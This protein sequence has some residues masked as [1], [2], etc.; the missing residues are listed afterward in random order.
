MNPT[1]SARELGSSV[2][3]RI[4]AHPFAFLAVALG[5]GYVA[6]GGLSSVITN[7]LMR[8]GGGLA[9]RYFILP[10]LSQTVSRVLGISEQD[11]GDD[12]DQREGANA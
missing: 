1:E 2:E 6:G 9:V 3:Q 8:F 12:D 5:A 7:R 4:R 11:V 10:A